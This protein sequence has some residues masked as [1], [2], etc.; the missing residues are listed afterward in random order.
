LRA[1]FFFFSLSRKDAKKLEKPFAAWRLCE[2]NFFFL[3][4][5][6]SLP[7]VGRRKEIGENLSDLP[8][9]GRLYTSFYLLSAQRR[10]GA[11]KKPLC[12]LAR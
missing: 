3:T 5:T 8:E 11:K 7:A 4:K 9:A 2:R 1:N 12:G 10:R 6:R